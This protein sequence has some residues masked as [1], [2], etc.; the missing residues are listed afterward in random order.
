M[1][2]PPDLVD[3]IMLDVSAAS[4]IPIT[5]LFGTSP[6]GFGTGESEGLNWR[7]QVESYRTHDLRP[8]LRYAYT[9]LFQTQEFSMV[10]DNWGIKFGAI[11]SPTEEQ[12]ATNRKLTAEADQIHIV[13]GVLDATEVKASRFGGAEYSSET[14]VSLDEPTEETTPGVDAEAAQLN[15][16]AEQATG[17]NE[18]EGQGGASVDKVQDTALN[19]AQVTA[20]LEL[21][22]EVGLGNIPAE[23]A[24]Q[25]ALVAYPTVSIQKAREMFLPAEKL[26]ATK[27]DVPPATIPSSAPPFSAPPT[28]PG[29]KTSRE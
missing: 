4:R 11:D 26:A 23:S 10:P 14:T 21:V 8:P 24:I 25:I 12:Q 17:G 9:L 5:R 13:T 18:F 20:L 29:S 1:A 16:E 6:G 19:G 3:R 15:A 27:P 2:G 7:Q 22:K 28:A